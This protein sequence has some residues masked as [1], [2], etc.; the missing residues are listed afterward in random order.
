VKVHVKAPVR[1]LEELTETTIGSAFDPMQL[2]RGQIFFFS[3]RDPR[4]FLS[5]DKDWG[6]SE[7]R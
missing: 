5:P 7:R 1:A 2:E 3:F 4:A 6:R